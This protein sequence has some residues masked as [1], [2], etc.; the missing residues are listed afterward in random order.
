[1]TLEQRIGNFLQSI[2]GYNG[3]RSREDR[4]DDDRRLREAIAQQ[5]SASVDAL[6]GVSAKLA[7]N[8]NLSRISNV[9]QLVGSTRLLA[10]RVRT[11]SYGYG[12]IFTDRDID[13]Y[14][15][16]QLRQFDSA[17]QKEADALGTLANR[18]AG[19]ADGPLETDLAAY[20]EELNRLGTLFDARSGV[21]DTARPN[22]DAEVLSLLETPEAP[23]VS[24]LAM[25]KVGDALSVQDDNYV[26]D[27]TVSFVEQDGQVN[28]ARVGTADDGKAIWL[29][30]GT[31]SAAGSARLVEGDGPGERPESTR[32]AKA[33]VHTGIESRE[34]VPAEYAYTASTGNDVTFWYAIGSETRTFAG[35]TLEDADISVYGQ[36]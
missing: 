12:G 27:A 28:L 20:G 36:A 30:G 23:T 19:S 29:V 5:L 32:Q 13:E 34:G 18:I 3:Y 9:E 8:R 22:Q 21:V 33:V 31:T 16:D 4:R 1:M 6:T 2:P 17:F 11:A 14:A 7:A 15:L 25:L 24:P 10:D 26:V 35:T